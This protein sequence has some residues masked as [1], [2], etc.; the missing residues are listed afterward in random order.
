MSVLA[1]ELNDVGI[2]VVHETHLGTEAIPA[3]PGYALL[4]GDRWISGA[5]A[6]RSARLKP[7][8]T[9]SR[10]WEELDT[11]PLKR[12][13]PRRLTRADLAHAHLESIWKMVGDVDEVILVVPGWYSD[14]QLGL[15][16]GI[17]RSCGMP[18]TAMI[19]TAVAASASV[20]EGRNLLHLDLHLH[21]TSA[22][23]LTRENGVK[24]QRV[25]VVKDVGQVSFLDGW[26][27][28]IAEIFVR[29]TRFDPL[30][31]AET[32]Q[33]LY[34]NL[35]RWFER[36]RRQESTAIKMEA[37]GK[38]YAIELSREQVVECAAPGYEAI[39]RQAKTL[40]LP[41]EET[42]LLLSDRLAELVGLEE[43]LSQE[44]NFKVHWLLPAA[45]CSGALLKKDLIRSVGG[46]GEEV[47]FV[48]RLPLD[49]PQRSKKPPAVALSPPG[50]MPP[51]THILVDG[52]AYP[53]S[54]K[55]AVPDSEVSDSSVV[56]SVY[57]LDHQVIVDDEIS[58]ATLLN[59]KRIEGKTVCA[60]GDR[61]Q[62]GSSGVEAQL[63]A[64]KDS[65]GPSKD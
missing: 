2:R 41:E 26:V 14:R 20:R 3:S 65:D 43:H 16:L 58:H 64:V 56:C 10:F 4:D 40:S 38:E 34:R 39:R 44:P 47:T 55:P 63:I 57:R 11:S 1:L 52:V 49:I 37:A 5:D 60:I 45:A 23:S 33:T 8:Y 6:A 18:V 59:G 13:F 25:E 22:T 17:A 42:V 24:R 9:H 61:L 46:E 48:T 28:L 50:S 27:K 15:I 54:S 12:P 51:P 19:D 31:L 53:I 21:R 36:L 35:P 7:R 29:H 62:I 30:H 32:E